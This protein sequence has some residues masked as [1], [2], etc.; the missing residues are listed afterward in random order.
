MKTTTSTA[1]QFD[2]SHIRIDEKLQGMR[3]A[4]FSRR[5]IAYSIDWI[6]IW[7]F[8]QF[9]LV[10]VPLGILFLIVKGRLNRIIGKSRRIIKK[11]VLY[12]GRKLEEN[13]TIESELKKRFTRGITLYMYILLYLPIVVIMIYFISMVFE[14]FFPQQYQSTLT[15][16]A[17]FGEYLIRP[18]T[19]LTNAIKLLSRFLG[20]FIYFSLFTWKW[21]GQ[22]VGKLLM[23]IK[24]VK[25]NGT[26]LT[27]WNCLER[28]SGYT[29][30]AAILFIGFFQYFWDRNAQTTHD[31][32]TETIVIEK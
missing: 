4:S 14:T 18:V 10:I 8:T 1:K 2:L 22:T 21:K 26:P 23:K 24:V 9:L 5:F 12:F 17:S 11:Q 3:L 28:A 29:A 32:I 6:I 7:C 31:K 15:Y 16:T 20:A 27:F 30:S 19:D 25:L 13:T